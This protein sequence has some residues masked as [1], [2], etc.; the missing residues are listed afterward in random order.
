MRKIALLL[1]TFAIIFFTAA[2]AVGANAVSI[3]P[4]LYYK[5]I[6]KHGLYSISVENTL[7]GSPTA[8]NMNV[9][10]SILEVDKGDTLLQLRLSVAGGTGHDCAYCEPAY[11]YGWVLFVDGEFV[12]ASDSWYGSSSCDNPAPLMEASYTLP[13]NTKA[14]IAITNTANLAA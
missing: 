10:N 5:T 14:G 2:F 6:A 13:S 3:N 4:E 7:Y 1:F 9:V 12:K 8:S 11:I